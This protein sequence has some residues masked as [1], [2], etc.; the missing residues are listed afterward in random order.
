M[1]FGQ[2]CNCMCSLLLLSTSSTQETRGAVLGFS[3]CFVPKEKRAQTWKMENNIICLE[4][5]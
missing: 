2:Q 1:F 3:L 4:F 5:S